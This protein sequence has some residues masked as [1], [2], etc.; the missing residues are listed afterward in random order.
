MGKNISSNNAVKKTKATE[1]E[2]DKESVL[3]E[4]GLS[5]KTS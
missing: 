4:I 1:E 2:R 5:R 3:F